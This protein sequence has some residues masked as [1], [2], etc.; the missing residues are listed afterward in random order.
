MT[1][2]RRESNDARRA[3]IYAAC[4]KL[5][6]MGVPQEA[7][8]PVIGFADSFV[9]HSVTIDEVRR[10]LRGQL[11]ESQRRMDTISPDVEPSHRASRVTDEYVRLR[12]ELRDLLF[13]I[14][15]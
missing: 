13:R 7:I 11:D 12:D 2:L 4:A 10:E 14:G 8:K 15:E 1:E 5:Q 9:E 6:E 3:R